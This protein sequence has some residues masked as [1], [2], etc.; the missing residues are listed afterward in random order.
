MSSLTLPGAVPA[1]PPDQ[2]VPAHYG[3]PHVEQRNLVA[4]RGFVDLSH[5]GVLRV[6]GSDRLSWLHSF[7]TQHLTA[8]APYTSTD[9]LI[10]S[11]HG[12]IEH[13]LAMVDDGTATW[14]HV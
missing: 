6:G 13:M 12:H 14:F 11:P 7:T 9:A 8:L 1:D 2:G 5:R 3:N 4:G 10:L